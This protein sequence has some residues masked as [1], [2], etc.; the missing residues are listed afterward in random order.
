MY[1]TKHLLFHAFACIGLFFLGVSW[2]APALSA[3]I[4]GVVVFPV[5][6]VTVCPAT[7][8]DVVPPDPRHA[9][10]QQMPLQKVNPQGSHI[11][12]F[13]KI[14][15]PGDMLDS[16]EPLGFGISAKASSFA[17]INNRE[18]GRNGSP[19]YNFSE[20]T[21]GRMD[22]AFPL[23]DGV[24]REGQNQVA[25]RM[26]SHA[27]LYEL[28]QPIHHIFIGPYE[29]PQSRILRDYSLSFFPFG[30]FILG[31][32]YFLVMAVVGKQ[33]FRAALLSLMSA[34]VACQLFAEVS[35]GL[36]AYDYPWHDYRL[37]F[38]LAGSIVFGV[39]LFVY[40]VHI[41]GRAHQRRWFA[42]IGIVTAFALLVPQGFDAKAAFS[43]L[44]QALL[45]LGCAVFYWKNNRRKTVS[46][47][48]ALIAFGTI[49]IFSK[50]EFL[51]IYYFYVVAALMVFLFIQ[52]ALAYGEEQTRRQEEELR[53]NTLQTVLDQREQDVSPQTLSLSEA[54]KIHRVS[55]ADII[56]ISG[57]DD[58]V[59]VKLKTGTSRLMSSTLTALEKQLP[60]IFLRV[61]RSHIVNTR[62]I[63]SLEREGSGTGR[64]LMACGE[65]I[66]VSRRIMPTIRK[67]LR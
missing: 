51:D 14:I 54:G 40:V 35:R 2:G 43:L 59:E 12:V 57:A 32:I 1:R 24:L 34:S 55:T 26:S 65:T 41:F 29:K 13:L 52:Q 22:V 9:S 33:S 15:V 64:L 31:A 17:Y 61:H 7:M 44:S 67:A 37:S 45:S 56:C 39:C 23:R 5:G 10:C 27:G 38:I 66:P 25:I 49:I 63:E 20:E 36:F 47:S 21:I 50:G 60:S 46:F 30:V 62:Y 8:T 4:E 58:Y 3:Q 11:W 42:L 18:I 16:Y 28:R 48:A 6:D 53:A 19:A